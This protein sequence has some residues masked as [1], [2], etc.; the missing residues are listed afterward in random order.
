MLTF[1]RFLTHCHFSVV[2][3]S[4]FSQGICF[5][6]LLK[7]VAAWQQHK[8]A[9]MPF[10]D[11]LNYPNDDLDA[12]SFS[13]ELSPSNGYFNDGGLSAANLIQDPSVDD[14][15]EP[16]TLI[17][18]P[19]HSSTG[20]TSRSSLHSSLPLSSSVSHNYAAPQS[21][22]SNTPIGPSSLY[23]PPPPRTSRRPQNILSEHT[24][25]MLNGPPPAYSPSPISPALP[26][27]ANGRRYSIFPEQH[28]ERGL[29]PQS[30]PQ[31]MGRPQ[32]IATEG[33]PLIG[34]TNPAQNS[35]YR[36]I[37]RN[38]RRYLKNILLFLLLLATVLAIM[39]SFLRGKSSVSY[40]SYLL[41]SHCPPSQGIPL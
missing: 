9:S 22:S 4:A 16:K 2:L 37:L 29:P 40:Y 7:R 12:E 10:S 41:L 34:D 38:T 17:S 6:L 31:S 15:L 30:Q 14:K 32:D 23:G 27:D 20:G 33:A 39:K 3:Q 8:T 18:P 26:E 19:Q 1:S 21:S 28:L 13:D 25:L 35:P 24:P 5:S 11:N 36:K